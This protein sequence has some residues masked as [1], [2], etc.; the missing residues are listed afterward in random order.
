V[1]LTVTE[2]PDGTIGDYR[3]VIRMA[4]LQ[5]ETQFSMST[6]TRDNRAYTYTDF[7][8]YADGTYRWSLD[9]DCRDEAVL[10]GNVVIVQGDVTVSTPVPEIT[11]C[12][13][14]G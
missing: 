4:G 14:E 9:Q 1:T 12:P 7:V 2:E 11:E 3:L 10:A 5:P 13:A 8:A 6:V